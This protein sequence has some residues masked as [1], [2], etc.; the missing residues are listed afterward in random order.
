LIIIAA[1]GIVVKLRAARAFPKGLGKKRSADKNE[2]RIPAFGLIDPLGRFAADGFEWAKEWGKHWG[3]VQVL[4]RIWV[5]GLFDPVFA[6]PASFPPRDDPIDAAALV[7][8]VQALKEA[9]DNLPRHA[10]RLARWRAKGGLARQD[11]V[12]KPGRL[13]PFRPGYAPG[14]H[15]TG[16]REIDFILRDCYHFAR[17]VWDKLPPLRSRRIGTAARALT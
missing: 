17:E 3:K 9:L 1:R 11:G 14:L 10:K 6:N 4:P 8:R 16:Q 12:N 5:P 15:R 7:R 13:T 2:D